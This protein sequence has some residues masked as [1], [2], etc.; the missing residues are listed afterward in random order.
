LVTSPLGS[1]YWTLWSASTLSNFADGI[2][3]V[4]LPLLAV[5]YTRS[6]ILVALVTVLAFLPWLLLAL[7][8]GALAD[9]LDR[10]RIMINANTVRA[11][12]LVGFAAAAALGV[13]TLWLLL[14]LALVVGCA[15]VFFDGTAQS[16]LPMLVD[17]ENLGRANG[18]L[19]AAREIM[20]NFAGQ[21][22]GGMLVAALAA[23]A[24]FAPAGLYAAAVGAL[25][26]IAGQCR[27]ARTGTASLG[28]DIAEGVA[29][30]W[31]HRLLRTLAL[32]TG[33]MNLANTAF[34]A[35]FVLYAVSDGSPMGLPAYAYGLLLTATAAGSTLAALASEPVQRLIGRTGL[36][37]TCVVIVGVAKAVPALTANV[38]W[39]AAAFLATGVGIMLW[40]VVAVS[41][42]QRIIPEELLG[43]V[44]SC[45]RLI[46]WGTL[47]L[48]ALLGGVVAE[49]VG[50][51]GL[52]A[53]TAALNLALL[54][55]FRTV[56]ERA[57][58]V[59]EA[60]S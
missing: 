56:T 20:E 57:I 4:A 3:R 5:H 19:Y 53:A 28:R 36:L 44:N 48:G 26:L 50:L 32:I 34:M 7:P 49:L 51:R 15:E 14:V 9:R 17:R 18:R 58:R 2:Y 46:A 42:R 35:V 8:V 43:R 55:C 47:P 22:A 31:R 33:V 1:R 11:C 13:D 39:V 21:A 37:V 41:L 25:L 60:P 10:R 38:A 40:N 29:Y 12:A 30:L 27:P 23:W 16:I 54:V 52:F 59:A 24:F 6:P 45:Y